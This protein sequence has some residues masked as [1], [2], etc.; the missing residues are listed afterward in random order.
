M[1]AN[2]LRKKDVE[3]LRKELIETLSEQFKLRMRQGA[4]Q[5]VRPSEFG[6]VRKQI[7]RIKTVLTEKRS[8]EAS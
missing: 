4:G 2:E 8:G 6:R 5:P 7:A 1:K 3:A